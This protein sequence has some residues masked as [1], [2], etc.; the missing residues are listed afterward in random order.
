VSQIRKSQKDLDQLN[1]YRLLNRGT[2]RTPTWL[3]FRE[4]MKH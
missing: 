4:I 3:Q 2:S 1:K